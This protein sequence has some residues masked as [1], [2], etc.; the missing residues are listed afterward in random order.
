MLGGIR[1]HSAGHDSL[2]FFLGRPT[3]KPG[4]LFYPV[5]YLFRATPG[6][7]IGLVAAAVLTW[8]RRWPFDTPVRRRSAFGLT[9]FAVL[10]AAEM[11]LGAKMFDRYISP[12]FLAL[13][14][15]AVLGLAG[16]VQLTLEWWTRRRARDAAGDT[17]SA[18]RPGHPQD[19]VIHP[20]PQDLPAAAAAS[21]RWGLVLGTVALAAVLLSHGL[22]AFSHHPY[23]FT[24]YNPLV[25]G[26]RTAPQVLFMGW[27]EGL[28]AAAEWLK[29]QPDAANLR[30]ISW[31]SDGPLSY[32]LQPGQKALSFYFTSYLLDADYA[33]LYAN[34]WQRGLPSPEI[35]QLFSGAG[36]GPHRA[37]R[38]AGAG[39]DLRR[40]QPTA[41]GLCPAST[42]QARRISVIACVCQ[43]IVLRNRPL[44]PVIAPRSRST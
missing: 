14:V 20:Y 42:R 44:P 22:F 37:I 13:D 15:V 6:A 40:A 28:D 31:Y 34:Q 17:R 32:F 24:Y 27:G 5:A 18:G 35:G 43:P 16:L 1:V 38:R 25:G 3:D 23:Y 39:A 26:S 11:T 36:A 30:V 21:P 9:A 10:F 7:L 12:V 19:E 8:G 29:Q 33:V 2:N 4:P 41:A